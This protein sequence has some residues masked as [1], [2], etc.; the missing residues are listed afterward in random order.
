MNEKYSAYSLLLDKTSKRIKQ[1]AQRRFNEMGLNIT[2]DQWAILKNLSERTGQNQKELSDALSKD[3]PTITRILDLLVNK[4][5]VE[6]LADPA[7]RRC[8]ILRLTSEGES[9]V[10]DNK[11]AIAEIRMKAWEGLTDSD[12]DH[13]K[14]VLESIYKNL[15]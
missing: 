14:S 9:V 2:V 4:G 5:Y 8:F 13:F 12:F 11:A 10:N 3:G 7:D 15:E 6:R 1:F